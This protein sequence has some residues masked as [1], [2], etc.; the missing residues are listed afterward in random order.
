MSQPLHAVDPRRCIRCA[1]CASVAP[2]LFALDG[3]SAR[4]VRPP[5]DD[6]ERAAV[7]AAVLLCPASAIH[8]EVDRAP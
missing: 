2:A 6:E 5:E 8:R 7:E 3:P 1:A 4:F